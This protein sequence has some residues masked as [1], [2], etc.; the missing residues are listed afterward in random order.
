[1]S[2]LEA[3]LRSE[4]QETRWDA[5]AIH[6]ERG[7]LIVVSPQLDLLTAAMAIAEDKKS[8]VETFLTA[9]LLRKAGEAEI[10]AFEQEDNPKFQFVI[11]QPFV[12][13]CPIG[14]ESETQAL[15]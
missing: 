11:V 5:L 4:M 15:N 6:A 8:D 1:M 13:A 9:G 12:L 2:S 10:A 7:R 14:D 3:K